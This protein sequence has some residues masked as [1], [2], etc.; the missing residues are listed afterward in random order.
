MANLSVTQQYLLFALEKS[1]GKLAPYEKEPFFLI[2]GGIIELISGGF[3]VRAEK[4]KLVQGKA[5]ENDLPHLKPLY[6][7]V[8]TQKKPKSA[9][10][11]GMSYLSGLTSKLISNL[12]QTFC[13][14]LVEAGCAEEVTKDGLFG[15]K[16]KYLV[17]VSAVDAAIAKLRDDFLKEEPL[18][19]DTAR[20]ALMLEKGELLNRYF[21]KYESKRFKNRLKEALNSESKDLLKEVLDAYEAAYATVAITASIGAM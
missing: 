12:T 6:D 14:S 11:I 8:A 2:A 4:G 21:S 3:L 5:L 15:E 1:K 9:S 7:L 19:P 20:L 17:D 10:E 13:R 16:K 18:S